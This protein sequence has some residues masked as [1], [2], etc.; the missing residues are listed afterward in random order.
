MKNKPQPLKTLFLNYSYYVDYNEQIKEFEEELKK[1]KYNKKT[2]HH[3]G[4]VKAKIAKL[5][6][7]QESRGKGGKKGEGYSVRRSGDATVLLLG[8]PS[9]GKST[10][11]NALTNAE[12]ETGAYAFTTLTVIPGT[13]EYKHAKIQVLDVPGIVKGASDGT[14]RGK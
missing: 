1:T 6:E 7:R 2:Q 13:L 3:I 5:R 4:L 8:F 12:S 9:A 11:L 14:G 10:L